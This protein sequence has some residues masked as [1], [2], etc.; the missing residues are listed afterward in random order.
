MWLLEYGL[1]TMN[2]VVVVQPFND[3]V[4]FVGSFGQAIASAH[5]LAKFPSMQAF[6]PTEEPAGF[7]G[8]TDERS[9]A[10]GAEHVHD[11][12]VEVGPVGG[13]SLIHI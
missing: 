4:L 6:V 8:R 7:A 5:R 10:H 11:E 1:A 3:V 13:L 12:F 2:P 9:P